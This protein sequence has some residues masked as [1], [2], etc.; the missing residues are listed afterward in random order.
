M[1][2]NNLS[3]KI[4]QAFQGSSDLASLIFISSNILSLKLHEQRGREREKKTRKVVILPVSQAVFSMFQI[5]TL[6]DPISVNFPQPACLISAE[7]THQ[8]C[9]YAN[10]MLSE[11]C[12]LFKAVEAVIAS[13]LISVGAPGQTRPQNQACR[14]RQSHH[15]LLVN[16][17]SFP[18]N[19]ISVTS[20]TQ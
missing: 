7:R 15:S 13:N 11:L 8:C 20:Q 16:G 1:I 12:L 17:S 10:F 4:M 14:P 5:S 3:R 6:S 18:P 2:N 9:V 19:L